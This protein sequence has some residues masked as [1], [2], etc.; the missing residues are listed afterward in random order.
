MGTRAGG[1]GEVERG[2]Y[3]GFHVAIKSVKQRPQLPVPPRSTSPASAVSPQAVITEPQCDVCW[4]GNHASVVSRGAADGVVQP[5]GSGTGIVIDHSSRSSRAD[6]DSDNLNNAAPTPRTPPGQQLEPQ[7]VHWHDSEPAP[8]ES[9]LSPEPVASAQDGPPPQPP[10]PLAADPQEQPHNPSVTRVPWWQCCCCPRTMRMR[11]KEALLVR[12][13]FALKG[14]EHPNVVQLF[15]YRI[16]P[17]QVV[18]EWMPNS[19]HDL[20]V[21]PENGGIVLV[22]ES[23]LIQRWSMKHWRY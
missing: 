1:N 21:Q 8:A 10:S 13:A 6:R 17:L 11:R 15:G 18:M 2:T 22:R 5:I 3:R 16:N 7:A 9:T 20:R 14:A 23:K 19:L 4:T 12:E